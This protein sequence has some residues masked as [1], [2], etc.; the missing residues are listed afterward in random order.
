MGGRGKG[1]GKGKNAKA[2]PKAKN[3]ARQKTAPTPEKA[4]AVLDLDAQVEDPTPTS[5]RRR[6]DRRSTDDQVDR[7]IDRKLAKKYPKELIDGSVA[8][9]GTTPRQMIADEVRNTKTQG[10]YLKQELWVL[11]FA[12]FPV[13]RGLVAL[14][15]APPA[16]QEVRAEVLEA[17][18]PLHEKNPVLRQ[19]D[20]LAQFL[21]L[22]NDLNETE[23]FGIVSAS[24]QSLTVT[25]SMYVKA[26]LALMRYAQRFAT[27]K[28]LTWK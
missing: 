25:E 17:L 2:K 1:S 12:K 10:E 16:N 19:A 11:F 7:I 18:A 26:M 23:I 22:A 9:D 28:I 14:M 6:L 24:Q 5:K 20:H 27:Y 8:T 4:P 13:H 3:A 21:S 15:P